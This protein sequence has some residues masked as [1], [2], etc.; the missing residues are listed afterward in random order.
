MSIKYYLQPNPIT[1]D[2]NDQSARVASNQ[3]FDVNGI[4]QKALKRGTTLT[5][6]D[7]RAV[8][9]LFC[10]VVTD[11]V[12]DG[13]SVLTPL[14][15]IRPGIT[16]VFSSITDNFDPNR[17]I[18]KASISA[19]ILLN[20]KMEAAEVEKIIGSQPVPVLLEFL[21]IN[22]QLANSKLTPGGIGQISGEELKFN[23]ANAAEGVFLK[24]SAGADSKVNV[25]ST[26]TEGRLV[27]IIPAGLTPGNYTLEVRK[28][29]GNAATLRTGTL[30]DAM[31]VS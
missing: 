11:E 9:N 31:L 23:P 21:D 6:T 26:R 18:K 13:N 15:N 4:V 22:S 1:P 12:A 20:Q 25:F 27:F 7:L 14:V 28:G 17:H 30:N 8:I 3:S 2:P 24:D 5:E 19:G 10:D 29:Y 16:G